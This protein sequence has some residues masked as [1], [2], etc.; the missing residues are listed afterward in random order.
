MGAHK[1]R[2]NNRNAQDFKIKRITMHK[3]YK[4]PFSLSNDI[5][6]LNFNRKPAQ[7][8]N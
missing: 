8:N 5:A 6:L 2:G 3:T 1:K 4:G 7:I